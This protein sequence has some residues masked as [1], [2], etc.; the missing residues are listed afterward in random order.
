MKHKCTEVT[1]RRLPF[2]L[3]AFLLACA[4]SCRQRSETSRTNKNTKIE[5]SKSE[6]KLQIVL[7]DIGHWQEGRNRVFTVFA[8]DTNWTSLQEHAINKMYSRG[9]FTFVFFFDD[10]NMTPDITNLKFT[11]VSEAVDYIYDLGYI[12]HCIAQYS[13]YPT[14]ISDFTKYP[15]K[16]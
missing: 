1:I 7:E 5:S 12:D 10:K 4:T 16:D 14:G 2:I 13:R 3:I 15:G 9:N 6:S 8:S 11:Y